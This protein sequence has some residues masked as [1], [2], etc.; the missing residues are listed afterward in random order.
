MNHLHLLPSSLLQADSFHLNLDFDQHESE[1]EEDG[2]L[3]DFTD[4]D[5]DFESDVTLEDFTPGSSVS[6]AKGHESE[7]VSKVVGAGGVKGGDSMALVPA[8]GAGPDPYLVDSD[9]EKDLLRGI[10]DEIRDM[11]RGEMQSELAVY[12]HKLKAIEAGRLPS[13]TDNASKEQEEE[14]KYPD[15]AGM[16]PE[17]R[18]AYIKMRKLD[19]ILEKKLKKEKEVKRDR[20]LLERRIRDEIGSLQA[21]GRVQRDIQVNTEKYLSLALPPSHNEGVIVDEPPVTPLF[22]TQVDEKDLQDR[23]KAQAPSAREEDQQ[24]SGAN[25]RSDGTASSVDGSSTNSRQHGRHKKRKKDF[26]KRNKELAANANDM[27]AMTDDEKERLLEL[28]SDLDALPEIPEEGLLNITEEDNPYQVALHPGEGF[29]PSDNERCTLTAIDHRLQS[30]MPEEDF[31]S[32]ASSV[33]S[34]APQQRLFTRV[35]ARAE[36]DFESYGEKALMETKEEREF[37][38]SLKSIEDQLATFQNADAAQTET[39]ALTEQQLDSLLDD[40][41]RSLSRVSMPADTPEFIHST[42]TL[43][44][45]RSQLMLNPPNLSE[46][47]LQKLLSEAHFP[48]YS[49]LLALQ[50][51]DTKRASNEETLQKLLSEAHFPLSSRLL[52]LQDDDTKRANGDDGSAIRA[53]TWKAI[54][55]ETLS[56]DESEGNSTATTPTTTAHTPIRQSSILPHPSLSDPSIHPTQARKT[57]FNRY[58]SQTSDSD[59]RESRVSLP[60]ICSSPLINMPQGNAASIPNNQAQQ[61]RGGLTRN[62]PSLDMVRNDLFADVGQLG[63]PGGLPMSGTPLLV[64]EIGGGQGQSTPVTPQPPPLSERSAAPPRPNRKSWEM[65]DLDP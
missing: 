10:K 45:A 55:E 12:E 59:G 52:A 64:E 38:A 37:Q 15:L 1:E 35:G 57:A 33:L 23:R 46:E 4:S 43:E 50:D 47:T 24:S 3:S 8:D 60:E 44:S 28:L 18:E 17:L 16:E 14:D 48:Q 32:I 11:V 49:R 31:R 29:L 6:L 25:S 39:P 5:L 13:A 62:S 26:I 58:S 20:I 40:C 61:D 22:Q 9:E 51:D 21:N 63:S 36:V 30:I 56:G 53:E 34:H 42:R 65:K 41:V 54:A 27:I 7:K 2:D 19:R